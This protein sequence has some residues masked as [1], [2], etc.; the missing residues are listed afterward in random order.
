MFSTITGLSFN[1]NSVSTKPVVLIR[2]TSLSKAKTPC[3]LTVKS[4]EP[5]VIII[6]KPSAFAFLSI[7]TVSIVNSCPTLGDSK[8][9]PA[10]TIIFSLS[11]RAKFTITFKASKG[12]FLSGVWLK[13]P[14]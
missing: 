10:I 8:R 9:S 6:S 4:C 14:M 5:G 1:L 13:A 2:P 11:L 3:P 7:L 12:A